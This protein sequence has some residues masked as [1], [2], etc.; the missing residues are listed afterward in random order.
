MDK[1][2]S[3]LEIVHKKH[4]LNTCKKIKHLINF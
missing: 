3:N 1:Y 4:L 2:L